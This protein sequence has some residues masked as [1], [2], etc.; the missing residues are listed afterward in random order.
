LNIFTAGNKYL[1][2]SGGEQHFFFALG[3]CHGD[4]FNQA[5]GGNAHRRA[6]RSYDRMLIPFETGEF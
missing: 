6:G 3:A 4:T 1:I 5:K 2:C